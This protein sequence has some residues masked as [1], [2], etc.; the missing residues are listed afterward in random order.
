MPIIIGGSGGGGGG[1]SP[2]TPPTS[3]GGGTGGGSTPYSAA[4]AA[5][6]PTNTISVLSGLQTIDGHTLVDGDRVLLTGNGTSNGLWIA[7]ATAWTR[8]TDMAAA[9]HAAAAQV[10][11][12]Y[13]AVY[14]GTVWE[15][16]T[17]APNDVVGANALTFAR[18]VADPIAPALVSVPVVN[19]DFEAGSLTGWTPFNDPGVD[20]PTI[21]TVQAHGGTYSALVGSSNDPTAGVSSIYQNVTLPAVSPGDTL[22]LS[23]WWWGSTHA[24]GFQF[25]EIIDATGTTLIAELFSNQNNL[26]AWAQRTFNLTPWAGQTVRLLFGVAQNGDGTPFGTYFYLDDVTI[27][28]TPA[29]AVVPMNSRI[30]TPDPVLATDGV[31]KRYVDARAGALHVEVATTA[32]ILATHATN[33]VGFPFYGTLSGI[34]DGQPL[35]DGMRIL[36][37]NETVGFLIYH[38]PWIVRDGTWERPTDFANGFNAEGC[39]VLVTKG[40]TQADQLFVCTSDFSFN[41]SPNPPPNGSTV[42]TDRLAWASIGAVTYSAT[43]PVA[44]SLTAGTPGSGTPAARA[45]HG[46]TLSL[47]I[48]PV[49]TGAHRFAV[50]A[51]LGFVKETY[52]ATITSHFQT[53]QPSSRYVS[54]ASSGP[55][56]VASGAP[57]IQRIQ[58]GGGLN[59][60]TTEGDLIFVQN[61]GNYPIVFVDQVYGNPPSSTAANLWLGAYL[62]GYQDTGFILN[63]GATAIFVAVGSPFPVWYLVRSDNAALVFNLDTPHTANFTIAQLTPGSNTTFAVDPTAGPIQVTL[64]GQTTTVTTGRQLRIKNVTA[65]TTPITVKGAAGVVV[66]GVNAGSV[67]MVQP[68]Q[69]LTLEYMNQWRVVSNGTTDTF[70]QS[71]GALITVAGVNQTIAP[72][73]PVH[74]LTMGGADTV[75]TITPKYTGFVGHQHFIADAL[76]TFVTGGNIASAFT[77]PA[78]TM[79]AVYYDGASWFPM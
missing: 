40:S 76:A 60:G 36:V 57:S 37:K 28:K 52:G 45:N 15:C 12:G 70:G 49:W 79:K 48:S 65:L 2:G 55:Y 1:G 33:V 25:G 51:R 42:G 10:A 77:I 56:D 24:N 74:H 8:A 31:S 6:Y 66:E 20:P 21:S 61:G 58:Y 44:V 29:P 75:S 4:V 7:H 73:S 67:V 34:I 5:V 22:A 64:G 17:A 23:F 16:T 72:T 26:H 41:G 50:G 39:V 59:P 69:C 32:S 71:L 46:H 35:Y 9:S 18:V 27:T 43:T 47:S 3:G 68:F 14:G 11:I 38:G 30:T 53:I 54:I 19:G 13:G 62:N 63:P 78:G